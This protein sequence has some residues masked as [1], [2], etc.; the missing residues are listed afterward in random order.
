MFRYH[1]INRKT[2]NKAAIS[3]TLLLTMNF[4]EIQWIKSLLICSNK[5]LFLLLYTVQSRFYASINLAV[6]IKLPDVILCLRP[7]GYCGLRTQNQTELIF[8]IM[9]G[10]KQKPQTWT[11]QRR[12]NY[13]L[14]KLDSKG[15][16]HRETSA[17]WW[18]NTDENRSWLVFHLHSGY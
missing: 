12:S 4:V 5:P 3:Y 18:T 9:I 13:S 6:H 2:Y 14:W 11:Q 10:R 7:H 17:H 8:V 16:S 15:S 1:L